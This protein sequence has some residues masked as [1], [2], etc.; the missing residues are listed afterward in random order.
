[1]ST[2]NNNIQK[3]ELLKKIESITT[4]DTISQFMEKCNNNFSAIVEYGGGPDGEKGVKGD[5]GVPTKPKVP[6]HVWIKGEEYE[7]ES[8]DQSENIYKIND[9]KDDELFNSKY[10]EGHLIL[11]DNGHVY[12]LELDDNFE[13]K[14]KFI[15]PIQS[16]D[17]GTII[18][19]KNAYIHIAYSDSP[20]PED[21]DYIED[22]DNNKNTIFKKY[23]GIYTDNLKTTEGINKNYYTWIRLGAAYTVKLSNPINII[24]INDDFYANVE[25]EY[26]TYVDLFENSENISSFISDISFS[27]PV[28]NT[29]SNNEKL[30]HFV[31]DEIEK[32]KIIFKPVIK[33]K[34]NNIIS[35]FK[36]DQND[37]VPNE[38]KEF[39]VPITITYTLNGNEFTTNTKWVLSPL[40]F[41]EVK[42]FVNKKIVNTSD[43]N[44]HTFSVGYHLIY[45][46]KKELIRENDENEKYKI[47]LTDN[48]ESIV[49][50]TN[51]IVDNWGKAEYN[52]I[53]EDNEYK[54]C[55]VVLLDENDKML[56]Y[57]T[58]STIKNG[59]NSIHLE[60]S[61]NYITLPCIYYNNITYI[62]PDY[63]D[64]IE[65]KMSLY[66]GDR[67]N[68]NDNE[69]DYI[70]NLIY[71]Q[72]DNNDSNNKKIDITKNVKVKN[73][74]VNIPIE[75]IKDYIN[76]NPNIECIA[77]Y[78]GIEYSKILSIKLENTPYEIEINK[79]LLTRDKE[80]K[81]LIDSNLI[82]SVKYWINGKWTYVQKNDKNSNILMT[83]SGSSENV[84]VT[85]LNDNKW[86]LNFNNISI[87]NDEE[88]KISYTYNS[89][90]IYSKYI[91][92]ADEYTSPT[93]K[94]KD[95]GYS[96]K[97]TKKGEYDT[98]EDIINNTDW[99]ENINDLNLNQLESNQKIYV[100]KEYNWSQNDETKNNI[101]QSIDF[102]LVGPQGPAG[103][104]N[105][106][107]T[108]A[109]TKECLNEENI[110]C[111]DY[112][113][114]EIDYKYSWYMMNSEYLCL[115]ASKEDIQT[116]EFKIQNIFE[117]SKFIIENA[118]NIYMNGSNLNGYDS[119]SEL[120]EDIIFEILLE[121]NHL[122]TLFVDKHKNVYLYS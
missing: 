111:C 67:L 98:E 96:L 82:V 91:N 43:S 71:T 54:T 84:T 42:V 62:H 112:I 93:A 21:S 7:E 15:I 83:F 19:G 1:M 18:E 26:Y 51:N 12:I 88:I 59:D 75:I 114:E 72:T 95:A 86:K 121:N 120:D 17:P 30:K 102:I 2:R 68:E 109:S 47:I 37:N 20:D 58:I 23:I 40:D 101:T 94:V 85:S 105:L 118:N 36:F 10:Q 28:E 107:H 29:D 8:Y 81:N 4:S 22:T 46:N 73:G 97:L 90:E 38:A 119:D 27:I 65:F 61:Q 103:S 77:K 55:Y 80:T 33:D 78:N 11:L 9:Y 57:D 100:K 69:I 6:I 108:S 116:I 115:D 64:P 41:K 5:Q 63:T 49:P 16:Y 89:Y 56:D 3:N 52:F 44:K 99:E 66:N 106:S 13:L 113:S 70:I 53:N 35:I 34:N 87:K 122:Y 74:I 45:P 31:K 79:N 76:N 104:N 110:N 50:N 60:L 92:F 14:P 24:P 48:L 117:N 32:N 39:E 25:K